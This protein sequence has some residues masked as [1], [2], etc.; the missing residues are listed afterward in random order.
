MNEFAHRDPPPWCIRDNAL[1]A[2]CVEYKSLHD[3]RRYKCG[4]GKGGNRGQKTCRT[5]KAAGVANCL[6]SETQS[7]GHW[8]VCRH[9]GEIMGLLYACVIPV[10]RFIPLFDKGNIG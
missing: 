5:Y 8:S 1:C 9:C 3:Y 7:I 6:H 2:N 4:M 10:P